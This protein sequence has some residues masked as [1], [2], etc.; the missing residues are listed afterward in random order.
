VKRPDLDALIRIAREA[1]EVVLEVYRAPFAVDFK[2][3]SDPVTEADRRANDLICARLAD[4]FP[5]IPIVAEESAPETFAGYRDSELIFF[6]DPLDGTRDFVL[7]NG[8]FVVM[9]GLVDG[10][11][12][13]LGVVHGPEA[14]LTWAGE[15]GVGAFEIAADGAR[16]SLSVSQ[17]ASLSEA[18]VVASRSHR[19]PETEEALRGL[20][21][22][23]LL[24]LGSAGLKGSRVASGLVEAYVSP[25]YAGKRW[26]ACAADALVH[27]AGGKVTDA[28]GDA[29]DYRAADLG[30]THGLLASNGVLHGALLARLAARRSA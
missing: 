4:E 15:L 23:E 5:G 11:R 18:R 24:T 25:F 8:E 20:G 7:K 9:I 6:V 2:A 27:A 16:R 12:S 19:S 28:H 14:G 30:N 10:E 22:R 29:F 21:A 17:V 13:A 3:P 1:S 26:D